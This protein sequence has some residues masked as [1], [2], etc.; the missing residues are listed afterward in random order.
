M[1]SNI[2]NQR[3]GLTGWMQITQFNQIYYNPTFIIDILECYVNHPFKFTFPV[4]W[5]RKRGTRSKVI[6]AA[7]IP[8]DPSCGSRLQDICVN[9]IM[10]Q[11]TQNLFFYRIIYQSV[12]LST[13]GCCIP[14]TNEVIV[15]RQKGP[16]LRPILLV[17]PTLFSLHSPSSCISFRF[18]G[19]FEKFSANSHAHRS[20]NP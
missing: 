1:N 13:A 5:Y 18:P 8:S 12:Y 20:E 11:N 15:T 9:L 17:K 10:A 14:C 4:H 16:L 19:C 7:S 3:V 6:R 2:Y